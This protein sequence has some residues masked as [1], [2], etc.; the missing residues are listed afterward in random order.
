MNE[1]LIEIGK[2][3]DRHPVEAIRPET[4]MKS[5]KSHM[6]TTATMHNGV[7][8]SPLLRYAINKSNEEY[9]Q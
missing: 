5:V 8:I 6:S 7:S 9:R 4:I 1:I 3:N 2:F